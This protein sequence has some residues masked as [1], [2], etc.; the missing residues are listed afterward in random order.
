M[1]MVEKTKSDKDVEKIVRYLTKTLDTAT[2]SL[3]K[4]NR[5]EKGPNRVYQIQTEFAYLLNELM[6]GP[7]C[8]LQSRITECNDF[9]DKVIQEKQSA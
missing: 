7:P 6:M 8:L 4:A 1:K 9:I 5:D 2:A 3:G